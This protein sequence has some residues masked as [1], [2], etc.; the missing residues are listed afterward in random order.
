MVYILGK[1]QDHSPL[2]GTG[3]YHSMCISLKQSDETET[4]HPEMRVTIY[5]YI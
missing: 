3:L 4:G 5:I 2:T 1:L